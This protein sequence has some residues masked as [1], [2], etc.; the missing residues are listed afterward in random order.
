MKFYL[1]INLQNILI[2]IHNKVILNLE[3]KFKLLSRNSLKVFSY[4]EK[5][6]C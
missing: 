2:H 3:K 6:Y 1:I 4:Y 5:K